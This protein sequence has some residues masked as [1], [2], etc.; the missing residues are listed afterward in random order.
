MEASAGQNGQLVS[1]VPALNVVGGI[2]LSISQ[3]LSLLQRLAE[4]HALL[5]HPGEN[6]VGGAIDDGIDG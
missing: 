2:S 6:V 1:G 3:F 5:G 4:S